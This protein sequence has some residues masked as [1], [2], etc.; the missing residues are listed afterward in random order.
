MSVTEIVKRAGSSVGSFYARFRD[1]DALLDY[2]DEGYAREVIAWQEEFIGADRRKPAS[3]RATVSELVTWLVCY[4]RRHRGLLRALVL[5]ARTRLEPRYR[6][7]TS[8][9]NQRLPEVRDVLLR[10]RG[11]I[12]H[13][14][15]ERAA[16]LGFSF[17]L[18]A[19]RERILFPEA[20][21]LPEATPDDV[22]IEE[23]TKAYLAYLGCGGEAGSGEKK[24]GGRPNR[25]RAP[26]GASSAKE[27]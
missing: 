20:I 24:A 10:H 7:R 14:R 18:G 6:E 25:N 5:R 27:A 22:L 13:P 1:K 19:L 21:E 23:I 12:R 4:H 9:M 11:E 16:A 2:L 17:A 8:R 3:L 26:R 15:P